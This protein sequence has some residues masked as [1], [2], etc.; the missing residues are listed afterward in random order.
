MK[1]IAACAWLLA[2][3]VAALGLF[4]IKH[5]VQGLESELGSAQESI[6]E[7]R[8]AIHVLKAEWSFLNQPKRISE[9]AVRHLDMARMT[10]ARV[11]EIA[12]LPL[13]AP[14][15]GD[16]SAESQETLTGTA[17]ASARRQQ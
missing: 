5:L 11:V 14:L 10:A 7:H 2:I 12:D 3:A 16:T 8:E 9:L 13:R 17:L 4:H 15:G 1:R 6:L